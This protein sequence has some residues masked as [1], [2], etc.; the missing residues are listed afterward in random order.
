MVLLQ[1]ERNRLVQCERR[2]VVR[3]EPGRRFRR[4]EEIAR[5]DVPGSLRM[6]ERVQEIAINREGV[7]G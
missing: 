3:Q 4:R 5:L 6:K 1:E 7:G 2:V